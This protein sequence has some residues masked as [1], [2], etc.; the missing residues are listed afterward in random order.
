MPVLMIFSDGGPDHRITY[1]SVKL[2]LIVLFKKLGVDTLIAGRTAPGNSWANPAERIMSILNLAIQNISLMREESTSAME[3]VLR[4]ANSMND[5]RTKSTKYPNLKEAWMESV[6]PLKTV[7]GER[8][9][10]L[11]LKEVPFTVHNA[12]QEVD[13]NAFERQVLTCVDGNLE[14]GKYTQQNV[15]SKLDYHEFLRTHCRERH[16]WFQ[17]KKCDNRTCCVAKMSDTEFPWLP[18]PM[19]SNDPAHYKPFDDVI[20]TETTEVDRPSSQTQTAKAVAEEIQGVRNQGLVAQNVRKIVRCYE[21]H[22]P[23]CVYSKKSLTVRESRAFERLLTKYDYCCG[24]VI[25]P[26]GDALEG[27][28]NVRLQIDCNTHVEFPYYASTLAQPHICAFCAAVG[29]T[30]N[31]DAIKTHRI[32]LPVCRDCVVIG[33]LPPKRNPIK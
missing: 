10:R 30:K 17:I 21:C 13:I 5:I 7:L 4:S 9:S 11:K 12:A 15:K 18:D 14:L 20:N 22:K 29:Q 28:V 31:Q 1:H 32:V 23:R 2:A 33:K 25:T 24:S 3:Q 19:M 6:K 8:T 27:V 16:Y 26:E